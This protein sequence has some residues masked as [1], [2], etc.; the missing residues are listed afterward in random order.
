MTIPKR[1]LVV[2]AYCLTILGFVRFSLETAAQFILGR[3]VI[4]SVAL[5]IT[6]ACGAI[7]WILRTHMEESTNG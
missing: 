2:L 4:G 6:V 1:L 7:V 3:P 5:A